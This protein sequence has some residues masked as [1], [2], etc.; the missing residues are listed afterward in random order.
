MGA[1]E[2]SYFAPAPDMSKHSQLCPGKLETIVSE[3]VLPPATS[4]GLA[5]ILLLYM[6]FLDDLHL[7][8][9]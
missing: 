2:E 8:Y 1:Y 6:V 9:S 5:S 3:S 7:S 4:T